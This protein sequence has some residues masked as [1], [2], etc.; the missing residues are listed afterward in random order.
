MPYR[1]TLGLPLGTSNIGLTLYARL[2]ETD[3]V[4]VGADITEGFTELGQGGYSWDYA[5]VPTGFRGWIR[6]Y[7]D[8]DDE[9]VSSAVVTPE[10]V[11][12][13]LHL[14]ADISSISS[15]DVP[16]PWTVDLPGTYDPGEAG[17]ILGQLSGATQIGSVAPTITDAGDILLIKGNDYLGSSKIVI[18]DSGDWPSLA[19]AT[20]WMEVFGSELE[21]EVISIGDPQT[22]GLELDDAVTQDL[23]LNRYNFKIRTQL[24]NGDKKVLGTGRIIFS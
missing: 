12:R 10:D 13:I 18:T 4:Q 14:D 24:T 8:S 22:V 21:M 23:P 15:E 11:E 3:D 5:S 2:F 17:Y 16:D 6:F 19:N 7:R 1:I 20:V 9:Q